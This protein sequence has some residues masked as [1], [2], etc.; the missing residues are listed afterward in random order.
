LLGAAAI[1]GGIAC[2]FAINQYLGLAALAGTAIASPFAFAAA[3]KVWPR[4]PIGRRMVLQPV[5]SRL[6]PPL[7]RL[8]EVGVAISELRPMGTCQFGDER[9][10]VRSDLGMIPP[11]AKVKVVNIDAG[12]LIVRPADQA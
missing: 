6:Q 2:C 9:V 8:G 11:G 10:E 3:M 4:T 5:E 7:I 1:V 12:R